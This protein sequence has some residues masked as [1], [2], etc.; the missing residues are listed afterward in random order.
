VGKT[1]VSSSGTSR[2]EVMACAAS[3]SIGTNLWYVP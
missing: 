3:L 1:T 2:S